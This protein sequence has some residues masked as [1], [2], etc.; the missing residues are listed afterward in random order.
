MKKG[1]SLG[2]TII[3][4]LIVVAILGIL[5][6]VFVPQFAAARTN[7]HNT[8]AQGY[9][10]NVAV[11]VASAETHSGTLTVGSLAGNCTSTKLLAEGAPEAFPDSVVDCLIGYDNSRYTIAVTSVTRKGGLTNNGVFTATY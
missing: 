3:E 11:W 8:A 2:F 5:L 4:L 10:H 9:A 6:T 1:S 7:A